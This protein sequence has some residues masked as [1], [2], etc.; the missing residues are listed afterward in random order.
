MGSGAKVKLLLACP[1][2][3][4][5]TFLHAALK[6][7]AEATDTSHLDST[8]QQQFSRSTSIDT[9][10][11]S[12][13]TLKNVRNGQVS[14]IFLSVRLSESPTF[15]ML[16]AAV[17]CFQAKLLMGLRKKLDTVSKQLL[18]PCQWKLFADHKSFPMSFTVVLCFYHGHYNCR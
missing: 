9:S 18:S 11:I 5:Y 6:C 10:G 8:T 1:L 16:W 7:I 14:I 4:I 2:L 17:K 12:G 15:D 13:L 3:G